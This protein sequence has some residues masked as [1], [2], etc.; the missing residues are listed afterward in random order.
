[1]SKKKEENEKVTLWCGVCRERSLFPIEI[2]RDAQVGTLKQAIFDQQR[3]GLQYNFPAS[4]LTLYLA[5]KDGAWLEDESQ[6]EAVLSGN[7]DATYVK[8]YDLWNLDAEKCFGP[9]F[10]PGRSEIRVLVEL[11]PSAFEASSNENSETTET[12]ERERY[13]HSSVK[14]LNGPALL[15]KMNIELKA[16]DTIPFAAD[17]GPAPVPAFHWRD[18]T[19]EETESS[20]DIDTARTSKPTLGLRC[21]KRTSCAW[22]SWKKARTS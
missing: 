13:A 16:V 17:S 4:A 1:M 9:D 19:G 18:D 20:S 11:P 7:I 12:S 2:A 22:W 3:Y 14:E 10:E 5:W 6:V 15:E 8:M 21:S